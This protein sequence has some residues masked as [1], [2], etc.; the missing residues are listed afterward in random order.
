MP[1]PARRDLLPEHGVFHVGARGAG[2]IAIFRDDDDR[3]FFLVLFAH[4]A[5]KYDW[6]SYALCLMG[7]HY[8]LVVE[9]RREQLSAGLQILHGVYAQTFN[10]KHNRWGHLFGERFWSRAIETDEQ[11]GT[12]CLYVIH[13]PVRA[14]L[15]ESPDEWRWSWLTR[16]F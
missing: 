2:K 5:R 4:V 9:A 11:L 3:R 14:G 6:E 13:N 8:H 12:T 16:R 10:G 15:C 1:R 7:K